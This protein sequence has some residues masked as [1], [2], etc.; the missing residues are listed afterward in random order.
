MVVVVGVGAVV[1]V[2]GDLYLLTSCIVLLSMSKVVNKWYTA[3]I[4]KIIAK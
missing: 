4:S 2:D 3:I 1:D